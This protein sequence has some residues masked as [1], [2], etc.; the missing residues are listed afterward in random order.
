MVILSNIA[1]FIAIIGATWKLSARLTNIENSQKNFP[2]LINIILGKEVV[3]IHKKVD[4]KLEKINDKV[5][6]LDKDLS[7]VRHNNNSTD[8]KI[9]L[10]IRKLK[11][12]WTG[13]R[14]E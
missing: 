8:T 3:D 6:K 12:I 2:D 10:L 1:I 7:K 9:N 14:F 5:A 11:Y 4:D 13:K